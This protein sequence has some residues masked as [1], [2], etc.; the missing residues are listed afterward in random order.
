MF[1]A[2]SAQ[3]KTSGIYIFCKYI[4]MQLEAVLFKWAALV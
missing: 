2:I 1:N 3:R 4:E